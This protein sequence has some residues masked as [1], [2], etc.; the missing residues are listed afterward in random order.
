MREEPGVSVLS[1]WFAVNL[2]LF[3]KL[4][5]FKKDI[6]KKKSIKLYTTSLSPSCPLLCVYYSSVKNM[7]W[8]LE[9]TLCPDW[10]TV[11][12]FVRAASFC[13]GRMFRNWL[14]GSPVD[15]HRAHFQAFAT[16]NGPVMHISVCLCVHVSGLHAS[17]SAGSLPRNRAVASK[18]AGVRVLGVNAMEVEVISLPK[19]RERDGV[20]LWGGRKL[21]YFTEHG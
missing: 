3:Y 9:V 13:I 2:K 20:G 16:V 11:L 7:R 10:G 5:I 8:I 17:I 12:T 14:T 15:G 21:S 4:F 18:C 19:G 1:L 6:L